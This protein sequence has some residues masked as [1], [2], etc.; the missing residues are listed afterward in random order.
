MPDIVISCDGV[1]NLLESLN[2]NKAYG[3]DNIPTRIMKLCVKEIAPILTVIFVQSLT[4]GHIPNDWLKANITPVFKKGNRNDANNYHPISLTAVC[5]KMLE[6]ILYHH[7]AEHLNTYNV[8]I[9]Q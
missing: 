2:P 3:L 5:C 8:L 7:I 1:Q 4:S 6:H 9:D